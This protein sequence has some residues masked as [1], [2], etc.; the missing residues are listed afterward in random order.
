MRYLYVFTRMAKIK[1]K[2]FTK[3]SV[4]EDISY[5]PRDV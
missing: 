2:R 1:S 5:I 3:L 4:G